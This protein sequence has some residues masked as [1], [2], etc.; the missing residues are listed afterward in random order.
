M[1]TKSFVF[2]GLRAGLGMAVLLTAPAVRGNSPDTTPNDGADYLELCPNSD[3]CASCGTDSGMVAYTAMAHGMP[4]WSVSEPYLNLWLRDVPLG[5]RPAKG[6]AVAFEL[7]NKQRELAAGLSTDV[8][9]VGARW[10]CAWLSYVSASPAWQVLLPGGGLLD[11]GYDTPEFFTGGR[12]TANVAGAYEITFPDGRTNVYAMVGS[13]YTRYYLTEMIDATGNRL[14][15][16]YADQ[17]NYPDTIRLLRVIDGDGATN[18][19]YYKTSGWSTNLID[20]V[21]D[22]FGHT[23]WLRYD[24]A[25]QLTNVTDVVGLAAS[26][27]YDANGWLVGLT[28]PYG[29]TGFQ[30]TD[31]PANSLRAVTVTDAGG[32]RH[33]WVYRGF[34]TMLA[35]SI[36]SFDTGPYSTS[37]TVRWSSAGDCSAWSSRTSANKNSRGRHSRRAGRRRPGGQRQ[38]FT[39]KWRQ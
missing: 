17:G 3:G 9:S 12:L 22:R 20:H 4:V 39:V 5:Y 31:D 21:T 33:L 13:D 28:T 27:S 6:P 2:V 30:F 18:S 7:L 25:G 16:Q 24:A 10:N 34:A 38:F 1:K 11:F 35:A 19:V 29:T 14:Q 32:G 15:F 37:L 23:N 36:P 8:F 26:F